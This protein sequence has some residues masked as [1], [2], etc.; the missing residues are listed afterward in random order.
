[1]SGALA[2]LRRRSLADGVVDQLLE[3]IAEGTEPERRLPVERVLC[4]Q[5]DVSRTTVREAL[6]TLT[7]VGV[8]ETRG[9]GRFG[10]LVGARA[11]MASRARS[12]SSETEL[13]DHPLEARR[14]L[15]PAIAALAAERASEADLED[16]A[17]WLALMR[18]ASERGQDNVRYD[19]AFHAAIAR[20]TGNPT[21]V[22]LINALTD[23]LAESRRLSFR[24]GSSAIT[25]IEGHAA[26][27]EA[28]R[29]RDAQAAAMAMQRHLEDVGEM[30]RST[31][32]D[33]GV[34][35]ADGEDG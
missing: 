3:Y 18:E 1:M 35:D 31:L 12:R 7:Q 15:E 14:V 32:G 4:E 20:A 5:L 23:A 29:A 33:R 10:S 24:P 13:V 26:V 9:K 25:A 30:I 17:R 6:S 19:S 16:I 2:P 22:F 8:V 21:L 34:E 27:L 11:Y 28:L